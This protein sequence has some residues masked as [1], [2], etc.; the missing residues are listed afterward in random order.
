M[1]YRRRHRRQSNSIG[2]SVTDVARIASRFGP[3]E[4]FIAGLLGFIVFYFFVPAALEY[5]VEYNKAKMTGQNAAVFRP[6][7]DTIFS[8]RFIRPSE[9]TG[10]AM[11]IL[12]SA[13][14]FWKLWTD[15]R[16]ARI[17]DRAGGFWARLFA[18]LL[19]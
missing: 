13:I 1:S 10:V 8:R 5:W 9:L 7:L 15:D 2:S 11:L 12:G 14:A 16:A 19:D 17:D 3:K 4:A 18:R 6:L